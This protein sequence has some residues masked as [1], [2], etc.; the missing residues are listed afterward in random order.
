[1]PQFQIRDLRPSEIKPALQLALPSVVRTVHDTPA[2][3]DHFL[4]YLAAQNLEIDWKL[5]IVAKD[6]LVGS[7]LGVVS[8]GKVAM[9]LASSCIPG[10]GQS[11][12][13]TQAL[14]MLEQ[15]ARRANLA[16]LQSLIPPNCSDRAQVLRQADYVFLADLCYLALNLP[17]S[18]P[19]QPRRPDVVVEDYRLVDGD[20]FRNTLGRTYEGSLDCPRLNGARTI[21]E[22]VQ[23]HRH[24]GIH[25]PK[26]WLVAKVGGIP[27]GMALLT[28]VPLQAA[29]EIVYIGVVPEARGRAYGSFLVRLA[30][31]NA[32]RTNCK[33]LMLAVDQRNHYARKIYSSFGFE[34]TDRRHAWIRTLRA[35]VSEL[36][37][38]CSQPR[39]SM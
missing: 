22:I 2:R 39:D 37:T 3:V 4:R 11:N 17:S 24:T 26:L 38:H 10:A 23:S 25:D 27:I 34:E 12:T 30:I 21:E 36:S 20:V 9:I 35:P 14:R 1:M 13:V 6:R 28:H 33:H 18:L 19:P 32:M 7:V 16:I 15:K 8:P 29:M 5:G 31:E